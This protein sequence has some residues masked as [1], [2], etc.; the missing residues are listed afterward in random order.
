M[1]GS[2]KCTAFGME[3][4]TRTEVKASTRPPIFSA[5]KDGSEGCGS[6]FGMEG[7]NY[8]VDNAS[9]VPSKAAVKGSSACEA[10]GMEGAIDME[11]KTSTAWSWKGRL[12]R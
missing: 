10:G 4:A 9:T 11:T 6:T 1:I 8:T 3:G 2:S 5:D 12:T 7:A